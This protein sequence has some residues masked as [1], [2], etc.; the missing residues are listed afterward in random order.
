[1]AMVATYLTSETHDPVE[2]ANWSLQN[3]YRVQ[4]NGTAW[5]YFGA[6]SNEYGLN[7]I[8]SPVST[9]AIMSSLENDNPIIM[10]MN[11]GD[12]TTRGHFIVLRGISDDGRIIVADPASELRSNQTWD[13]SVFLQQGA[14]MWSFSN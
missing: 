1:M 6:I 10:S 12:F 8:Q 3:G 11:P 4:G 2:T 9:E 13:I 7:C 14:Q 5:T